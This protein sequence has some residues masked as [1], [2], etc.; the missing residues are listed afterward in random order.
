MSVA[1]KIWVLPS[2]DGVLSLLVLDL[3]LECDIVLSPHWSAVLLIP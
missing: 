3:L 2:L 1:V